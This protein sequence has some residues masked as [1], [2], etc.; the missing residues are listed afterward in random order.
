MV[1]VPRAATSAIPAASTHRSGRL[2]KEGSENPDALLDFR[3]LFRPPGI[4]FT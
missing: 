2:E 3:F 4:R 1:A